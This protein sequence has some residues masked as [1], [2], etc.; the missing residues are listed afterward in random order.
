MRSE[1]QAAVD[2]LY[3][4]FG[5]YQ[6]VE[7]VEYCDHCVDPEQVEALHRTPLRQ[8]TAE[9]LGPLLFNSTT[10]WGDQRYLNHF[11]PRLLELV[12]AGE[13][14]DRSY[15]VFLPSRLAGLWR[16]G[17][18]DERR[19]ISD[20]AWAWWWETTATC[21][22]VC[23]PREVLDTI[24][25][26]GQNVSPYLAAWPVHVGKPAARQLAVL[27]SDLLVSSRQDN[28][29]WCEVNDWLSGPMPADVLAAEVSA[30]ADPDIAL[31]LS[32]AFEHLALWRQSQTATT[33]RR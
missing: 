29:F 7:S 33:T 16:S 22:S 14:N 11:M 18:D 10:T 17:W 26:C 25:E 5:R 19:V 6:L 1:L 23:E 13:M 4:V 20:F 32:D 21:P 30:T 24:A 12:A 31:Q 2:D 15:H 8:V 28:G 27:V 9:Q 3:R